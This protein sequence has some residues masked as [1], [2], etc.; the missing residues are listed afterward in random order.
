MVKKKDQEIV[1]VRK[2]MELMVI[3]FE[4]QESSLRKK[5]TEQTN[6]LSDQID[7]LSKTKIRFE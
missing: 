3:Q 4:S 1:K 2:D 5:Y 6:D 7:Y